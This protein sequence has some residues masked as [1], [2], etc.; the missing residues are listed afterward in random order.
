MQVRVDGLVVSKHP[1][2]RRVKGYSC[3]GCVPHNPANLEGDIVLLIMITTERR[4]PGW[5]AW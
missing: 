2:L 4:M 1:N 3:H 5:S